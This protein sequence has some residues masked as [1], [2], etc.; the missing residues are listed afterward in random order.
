MH[1][2]RGRPEWGKVQAWNKAM[3]D[4]FARCFKKMAVQ[5][6]TVIIICSFSCIVMRSCNMLAIPYVEGN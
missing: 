3:K 6:C 5:V 2:Q 4:V 1:A